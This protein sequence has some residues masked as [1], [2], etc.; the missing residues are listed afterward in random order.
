MLSV[1]GRGALTL[2][3][4]QLVLEEKPPWGFWLLPRQERRLVQNH[5]QGGLGGFSYSEIFNV[6]NTKIFFISFDSQG[7]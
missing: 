6:F 1:L 7:K 3:R 5:F 4:L 2:L